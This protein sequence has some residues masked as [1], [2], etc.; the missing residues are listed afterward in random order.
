[1][2]LKKFI[3]YFY[4]KK[5]DKVLA[6]FFSLLSI[7]LLYAEN[8]VEIY[9]LARENDPIILQAKQAQLANSENLVIARAKFLPNI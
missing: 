3:T 4:S 9:L 1:M 6:L 2:L 8:L 5:F 7:N